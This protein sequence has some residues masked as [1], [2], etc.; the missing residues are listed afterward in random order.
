M[1]NNFKFDFRQLK[2]F[3][4]DKLKLISSIKFKVRPTIVSQNVQQLTSN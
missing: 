1:K 2:K 4:K 3:R